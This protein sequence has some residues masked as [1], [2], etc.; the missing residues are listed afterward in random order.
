M[1]DPHTA[2]TA[3]LRAG[4]IA[5]WSF[6][7]VAAASFALGCPPEKPSERADS[8][9]SE[10]S[11]ASEP[12]GP[13]EY[14]RRGD[15]EILATVDGEVIAR[16]DL[17]RLL[18]RLPEYA[19]ARLRASLESEG[20]RRQYLRSLVQ[21]EVMADRAERQGLG[22]A[23][24]VRDALKSAVAERAIR[25]ELRSRVSLDDVSE[26]EI[27]AYYRENAEEYRQPERRAGLVLATESRDRA[28]RIRDEL[29]GVEGSVEER[30]RAF[31]TRASRASVDSASARNG[32][33][34]GWIAAPELEEAQPERPR[35]ADVIFGLD[36]KGEVS[37]VFRV[38]DRWYV[39][40]WR[41]RRSA[42][43]R[44]LADVASDIRS[45]LYERRRRR[46]RD[47]LVEAWRDD[48]DIEIDDSAVERLEAPA[49][50]RRSRIEEIP[51]RT[52]ENV[53][54]QKIGGQKRDDQKKDEQ[55]SRELE[56]D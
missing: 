19:R 47:K 28:R 30:I 27:E 26:D 41:D 37:N 22:G 53:S 52:P 20:A 46:E 9:K 29:A 15:R 42:S 2:S 36:E 11:A 4:G 45:K 25:D 32:G 49:P 50:R 1:S 16:S 8:E 40:M 31:R 56:E 18:E 10:P 43:R 48:A 14:A 7:L 35:V 39:A 55:K 24:E 13:G 3:T 12:T 23:P 54:G 5:H 6:V 51:V 38:G 21:F 17:E 44:P 34:V 33:D